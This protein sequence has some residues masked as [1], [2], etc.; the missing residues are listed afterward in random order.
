M[1]KDVSISIWFHGTLSRD[2]AV[3]LLELKPIGSFLVRLS[4]KIWGYTISVK[5][6]TECKHFLIDASSGKYH[7]VG[8]KQQKFNRLPDLLK[9]YRVNPITWA[10]QEVLLLPVGQEEEEGKV[11]QGLFQDDSDDKELSHL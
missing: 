2:G 1:E 7:F 9:F 5:T 3:K 4:T 6:Y 10:G 8:P 11:F